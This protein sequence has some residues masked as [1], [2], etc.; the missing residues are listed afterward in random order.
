LPTIIS[1]ADVSSEM[2]ARSVARPVADAERVAVGWRL[3]AARRADAGAGT[4]D[5]L[6]HHRLAERDAHAVGQDTRQ[7]VGRA[8]GRERHDDRDR[9]GGKFLRRR[10][11]DV[12]DGG[13]NG[14]KQQPGHAFLLQHCC[15]D[16]TITQIAARVTET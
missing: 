16:F 3:G 9:S 13:K 6:D 2:C 8:A 15:F 12:Q 14:S 4:G 7:C 1:G 5:V 11:D 10:A